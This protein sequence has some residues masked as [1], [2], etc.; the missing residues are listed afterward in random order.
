[1]VVARQAMRSR[2]AQDPPQHAAERVARQ[3][4]ISDMVGRHDWSCHILKKRPGNSDGGTGRPTRLF[5]QCYSLYPPKSA[6]RWR[7]RSQAVFGKLKWRLLLPGASE[8]RLTEL[9]PSGL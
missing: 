1:M 2:I 4:I 7:E 8:P 6:G 9:N 5:G 3:H